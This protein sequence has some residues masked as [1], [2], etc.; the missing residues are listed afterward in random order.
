M[1]P[2][3]FLNEEGRFAKQNTYRTD[4]HYGLWQSVA[5][6]DLDDDGDLDILLGNFGHNSRHSATMQK[7]LKM[8][9]EDLDHNGSIDPILS[10]WSAFSNKYYTYQTR[11]EIA[12]G[13]PKIKEHFTDYKS[14]AEAN[15]SQVIAAFSG[16]GKFLKATTLSSLILENDGAGHFKP[17]PFP[18][19]VDLSM[20]NGF[21]VDDFNKDNIKDV[22]LLTN[23]T[24]MEIQNGNLNGLNGCILLGEGDL[25]FKTMKV[26][27]TNFCFPGESYQMIKPKDNAYWVSS[28]TGVY[29]V[30]R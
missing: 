23:C 17:V 16:K 3:L 30:R 19:E 25:Q 18:D 14:F 27:A 10:H 2:T 24:A 6:H 26:P 12:K 7:P 5:V 9:V 4:E 15:L 29:L 28:S 13:L 1:P 20:V 8:L 11:D 22:A 21:C